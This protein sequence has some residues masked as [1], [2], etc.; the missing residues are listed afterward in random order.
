M[1]KRAKKKRGIWS[2]ILLLVIL[3]AG[4]SLLLYPT[5]SDYWNSFT[6]SRAVANYAEQLK[7]LDDTQYDQLWSDAQ[8]YNHDLA[9][10][11]GG[12]VLPKEMETR[13]YEQLAV[14]DSGIMGLVEIPAIGVN[15]PI[16]HGTSE[17]VLQ[18]AI[19]HLDWTSL[20]IG[21]KSTHCVISGHRGLPSAKLF[22][23][24]D[25]LSEGDIFMLRILNETLTYEIDQILIVD[26]HE[27][28]PLYIVDGKDYCTL[29]T[30]TP[31]GINSHRMLVRGSRIENTEE[32]KEVRISANAVKIDPMIVAPV[33]A[34]PILL[35]LLVKLMLP[36]KKRRKKSEELD[37]TE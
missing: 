24:L 11:P 7:N 33:V 18:V 29:L 27:V 10:M 9:K 3:L 20:P 12:V 30:C 14:D 16:Y 31:Y 17:E 15:L 23:H 36:G 5:V 25:Q 32:A 34:I 19:G 13:Y 1:K 8:A 4:L 37:E 35:I 26:P 22:T 2:T 6:Q 21:G 28:T